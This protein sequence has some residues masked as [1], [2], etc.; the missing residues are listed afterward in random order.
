[1][2]QRSNS[3]RI[4]PRYPFEGRIGIRLE[5]GKGDALVGGWARDISE[6]G[7]CAFVAARL[8]IGESVILEVA[9]VGAPLI[10]P[11]IVARN[12]GTEYG[13]QFT[14]LSSKQRTCI[15]SA[16]HGKTPITVPKSIL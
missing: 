15:Q 10:I 9:F 11:A 4:V 12:L 3:T 5:R 6:S 14:A 8:V 7:I 1:M 2:S 13:F 16:T